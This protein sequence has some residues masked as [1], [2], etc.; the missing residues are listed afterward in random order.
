MGPPE[1]TGAR[2]ITL[3]RREATTQANSLLADIQHSEQLEA[4]G[5]TESKVNACSQCKQTLVRDHV[6]KSKKPLWYVPDALIPISFTKCHSDT[7]LKDLE[8]I[9]KN[10]S[11][12]KD[13]ARSSMLQIPETPAPPNR[14]ESSISL[15]RAASGDIAHLVLA[16]NL[17][18]LQSL[19]T[20]AGKDQTLGLALERNK[21]QA[22]A[23]PHASSN[24]VRNESRGI[25]EELSETHDARKSP[26]G[27]SNPRKRRLPWI[28]Q[29]SHPTE[30]NL[31]EKT[32][33]PTIK[34][35]RHLENQQVRTNEVEDHDSNP[36]KAPDHMET[37][38]HKSDY[39]TQKRT[40]ELRRQN[41]QLKESL[42]ESKSALRNHASRN[43]ALTSQLRKMEDSMKQK[44]HALQAL[45]K[46]LED[47]RNKAS[48]SGE[49]HPPFS[50][51]RAYISP[52]TETQEQSL[53]FNSTLANNGN[54]EDVVQA[55]PSNRSDKR[56]PQVSNVLE[57]GRGTKDVVSPDTDDTPV[58]RLA[59]LDAALLA[60]QPHQKQGSSRTTIPASQRE[61]GSINP[62]EAYPEFRINPSGQNEGASK[63]AKIGRKAAFGQ[64]QTLN[65]SSRRDG[66]SNHDTDSSVA[67]N[68]L[69]GVP[70][71]PVPVIHNGRLAIRD[72]TLVRMTKHCLG[73]KIGL[74]LVRDQMG[75]CPVQGVFF[76]L[77][78]RFRMAESFF[79]SIAATGIS[80]LPL[81]FDEHCVVLLATISGAVITVCSLYTPSLVASSLL[82]LSN[83]LTL[84]IVCGVAS[85]RMSQVRHFHS[86][87]SMLPSSFL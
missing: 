63:K 82:G 55:D 11:V 37:E 8:N 2:L 83:D 87:A 33:Q 42:A 85:I 13:E 38:A 14:T 53:R 6:D 67:F 58:S 49:Q 73:L 10:D 68:E 16:S 75:N 80:K 31:L 62:L 79:Q 41:V 45:R 64:R 57:S 4:E 59:I 56:N 39:T 61:Y 46:E 66:S 81:S 69:L 3:P 60:Q 78:Q 20:I 34:R 52:G 25:P 74:R 29:A 71:N 44:D 35:I 26:D 51:K 27:L 17:Q 24:H 32:G 36:L 84:C 40:E 23:Q 28:T 54:K 9:R 19:A 1:S 70:K 22:R 65:D 43:A 86:R 7:C 50:D 12:N 30:K 77:D 47:A 48:L 72:G 5:N 21:A 18:P 76:M 15:A